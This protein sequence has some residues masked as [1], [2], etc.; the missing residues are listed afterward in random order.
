MKAELR[1]RNDSVKLEIRAYCSQ[2]R[3][4]DTGEGI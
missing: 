3:E 1:G 4:G 2:Q